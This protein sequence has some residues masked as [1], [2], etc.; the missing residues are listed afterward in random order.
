MR[1]DNLFGFLYNFPEL[2]SRYPFGIPRAETT[3]QVIESV[4]LYQ[5]TNFIL[6]TIFN[7]GG[8]LSLLGI[9]C[10]LGLSLVYCLSSFSRSSLSIEE[11]AAVT[12]FI[13]LLTYFFQRQTLIETCAFAVLYSYFL[14]R[15]LSSRVSRTYGKV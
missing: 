1:E 2:L 12:S 3:Q 9:I 8:L 13:P 5:G 14:I 15:F 6:S 4:D 11:K 7:D 10:L